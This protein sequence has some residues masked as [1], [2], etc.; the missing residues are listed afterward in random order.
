MS[1]NT[2]TAAQWVERWDRQQQRYAFDREERFTVVADVV[3][4]V[5]AGRS[6][7][8]VAD[9]G[10]GPGSMAVRLSRRLPQARVIAVD[11]DPLLLELGRTLEEGMIRYVEA[12]I[13]EDGWTDALGL[14]QPLDAA[15]STTAFH[16]LPAAVLQR[17]YTQLA[18]ILRPGGVLVNADHLQQEAA[19]DI[20]AHVGRRRATRQSAFA[21][22]DWES[23]WA[24][25]ERD[26]ALTH[27][28]NERRRRRGSRGDTSAGNGL[29]LSR[30]TAMLRAAGFAQAG[31]VW[32]VGNSCVLVA[33]R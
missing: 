3:E 11:M 31:P 33:V 24:A 22:E 10:C 4:H 7:P 29:T 17:V 27:L 25:A 8:A 20:A 14:D 21:H 26:P 28:F 2:A 9:L 6:A 13:G 32:Q 19:A 16:Y 23:W 18:A 30:H 15:V 1:L 5:T 12:V